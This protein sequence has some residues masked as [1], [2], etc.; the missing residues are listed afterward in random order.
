VFIATKL[1][2]C[3]VK[4]RDLVH[5]CARHAHKDERLVL[6]E[7]SKEYWRWTDTIIYHE[8]VV[9]TTLCFDMELDNPYPKVIRFVDELKGLF[10]FVW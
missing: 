2:E 1:E 5:C 6:S 7:T 8:E 10:V 9:L 4:L 3:P